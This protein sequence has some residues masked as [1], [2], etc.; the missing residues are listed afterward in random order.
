MTWAGA[1][2]EQLGCSCGIAEMLLSFLSLSALP[3]V[4][5]GAELLPALQGK[6]LDPRRDRGCV[7]CIAPRGQRMSRKQ[8]DQP[9]LQ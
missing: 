7:P 4:W 8:P 3:R 9:A 1:G 2:E 5:A 6:G